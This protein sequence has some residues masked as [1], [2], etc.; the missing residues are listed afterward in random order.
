MVIQTTIPLC[1]LL[2]LLPGQQAQ[3]F[4]SILK[5]IGEMANGL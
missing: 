2:E 4:W 5:T 3:I 1:L